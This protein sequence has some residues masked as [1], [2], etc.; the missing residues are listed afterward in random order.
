LQ[1]CRPRGR[2]PGSRGKGITR[3]RAKRKPGS[4][5]TYSWE[6]KKVLGSVREWTLT[7]PRQLPLGKMESWWIPETSESDCRGQTSMDCGVLYINRKLLKRRCLKWLALLIWTSEIQVMAKERVGSRAANLTPDHKKSRIDLFLMS[8]SRVQHGVAKLS[9][10][11]T[12]LLQTAL[13][14]KFCSQSYRAPKSRESH[15]ARFQDSHSGV[16]GKIAIWM[17]AP[18]RVTEYTIR[19]KVVAPP[20]SGPWWVLC[21]RVA[22]GSS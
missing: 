14:S 10:R 16:P 18:W 13:R 2:K 12:T 22:R 4:H 17:W 5:I 19:G 21:V 1:G 6:C 9:T 20:K 8:D 11:A 15:L 3:V 7:L